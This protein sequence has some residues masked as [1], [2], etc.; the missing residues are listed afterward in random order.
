MCVRN[1]SVLIKT[2][3]RTAA[4]KPATLPRRTRPPV[5]TLGRAARCHVP[6]RSRSVHPPASSRPSNSCRPGSA[7]YTSA[8][9]GT[10]FALSKS[11]KALLSS[12]NS[13]VKNEP[14]SDTRS[15]RSCTRPERTAAWA[16]CRTNAAN[17][18]SSN[19]AAGMGRCAPVPCDPLHASQC[20]RN[21]ATPPVTKPVCPHLGQAAELTAGSGT[22]GV[23]PP[24][25]ATA[26]R[27][28]CKMPPRWCSLRRE[29]SCWG[30]N[31]RQ[32]ASSKELRY[33]APCRRP[34]PTCIL[35]AISTAN[36]SPPRRKHADALGT[37]A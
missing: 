24:V 27:A 19:T 30:K 12:P 20:L 36:T 7:T 2:E 26:A 14:I 1:S 33:G 10:N 6:N 4:S 37:S 28:C 16:A 31:T 15:L 21:R 25:H 35:A 17:T 23:G 18:L 29:D 9:P 22:A 3:F 34:P 32:A 8:V 11:P 13:N 5:P